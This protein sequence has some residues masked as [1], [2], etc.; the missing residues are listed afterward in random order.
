MN[1]P[2]PP[3][4]RPDAP[5]RARITQSAGFKILVLGAL[6]LGLLI[7]ALLVRDL[8]R[9][10]SRRAEQVRAEIATRWGGSQSLVGPMLVVPYE[11]L[12]ETTTPDDASRSR[13]VEC[14]ALLLP[15]DVEWRGRLEPEVRRRGLYEAVV[16]SAPLAGDLR[17]DL[18][19]LEERVS[20]LDVRASAIRLERARLVVGVGDLRGLVGRPTLRWRDRAAPFEPGD[21]G[22][23]LPNALHVPLADLLDDAGFAALEKATARPSSGQR[24]LALSLSLELRGTGDLRFVP[25]GDETRLALESPWP[26]PSFDGAALPSS[27]EVGVDGFEAAWSVPHFAR[28]FPRLVR[29]GEIEGPILLASAFGVEFQ[30]PANGYH[31]TERS[32]KH[33]ILFYVL[34]FAL[35]FLLEV[36]GRR[37]LHGMHYLLV[38]AALCLF[39]LLLLALTEHF[40]FAAAYLGASAGTVLLI[41]GY[42]AA[43]LASWA[44]AA[45]VVAVLGALYGYLYVLLGAE[46][47][48]LLLG[49]LGLFLVLGLLMYL[50]RRLDWSTL[51]T[52][53]ASSR[54]DQALPDT[55]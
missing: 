10:R 31:R 55:P 17:F 22:A 42:V 30:L 45:T 35:L 13:L 47:L 39:H 48:A 16:Y 1:D 21:A 50:T 51:Q 40:G 3:P 54:P 20:E 52:T 37:R 9:E 49:A 38:G 29:P 6:V 2:Q 46:D 32:A 24:V 34:V 33:A 14:L 19:R 53:S 8:I 36:F 28:G 18:D 15:S 25:A 23:A 27:R 7:P 41:G 26:S 11:A 4:P 5:P 44:A 12:V 43:I